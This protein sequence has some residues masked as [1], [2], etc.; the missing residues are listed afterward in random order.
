MAIKNCF[1]V[2][3]CIVFLLLS[4]TAYSVE[5]G[6]ID[7]LRQTSKA[8]AS[9]AKKVSPSVVFVKVESIQKAREST[10]AQSPFNDDLFRHF[11]GDRYQGFR[12][13][14]QPR[15][16]RKVTGQGSGF[17]FAV[18]DG[19]SSD[20]RYILTNNHVIEGADSIRVTFQDGREFDAEIKGVDPKSDVAV[21]AIKNSEH[22]A[23]RLGDS[24]SMEVGEWVIALGNPFGLSHTLTVGVVS[25]KGR[26]GL[27]INDYEDFIQTDA[28]INPGN[29]GGPLLNL[30]GEV[31]GINTAIFS[32]SGGY[33]GVGFA[34]PINLA[35]NIAN[36]LINTGEVKRGYLG[37]V[38]QEMTPELEESFGIGED[39]GILISQ[40]SDGSPAQRAGLK[41]GDLI[42]KY[43][44]IKVEDVAGF[45]NRV[46]LTPPGTKATIT[47]L[48]DAKE[49]RITVTLASLDEARD[50]A[51][52]EIQ[53]VGEL[54][55][56]VQ[57]ITSELEQQLGVRSG[58]GVVVTEVKRGSVAAMA[59]LRAGSVIMQ[60]NRH[61]VNSGADFSN[62]LKQH[63]LG[64]QILFLVSEQGMARYV[65]L[66]W[67]K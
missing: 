61:T 44:S 49:K 14:T 23:L 56:T 62:A 60:V 15:P 11:F 6:G 66:S 67:P 31:V 58:Q 43:Q 29:S 46:A 40:V 57:T 25:A 21:L 32:R 42:V 24:S 22:K 17:V 3:V 26:S 65:V 39:K 48:R 18:D 59:G 47:V 63:R 33:M 37:V 5:N 45:R 20:T 30:D 2:S 41:T 51:Q 53:S 34:I 13:Q 1:F 54:G 12:D 64:K 52:S 38:I 19:L 16:E 50:I 28:A 7:S 55:L 10:R 8:F 9:V 4:S 36:Q 35:K 27:G